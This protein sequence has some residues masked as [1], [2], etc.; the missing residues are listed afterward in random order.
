MDE[1]DVQ[2]EPPGLHSDT[3]KRPD[4]RTLVPW[5]SGRYLAWDATI[6][7]T[8]AA[9]Y[10]TQSARG[11][12]SLANSKET[13]KIR[14]YEGLPDSFIFQPISL[15]TLGTLGKRTEE[16]LRE[17]GARVVAETAQPRAGEYL[18]QRLSID[19]QRGNAVAVTLTIPHGAGLPEMP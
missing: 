4:G 19:V 16:F 6:S 12:G 8:L 2:M 15:E 14:K 18:L 5:K 3:A 13:L 10:R 7:H 17:L 1:E 9:S 11:A